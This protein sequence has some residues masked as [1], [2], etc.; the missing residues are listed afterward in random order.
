MEPPD[1]EDWR[2][3]WKME[4]ARIVIFFVDGNSNVQ[5]IEPSDY[6]SLFKIALALALGNLHSYHSC[7]FWKKKN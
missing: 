4:N 6:I 7:P 3:T 2:K 5:Q 1:T